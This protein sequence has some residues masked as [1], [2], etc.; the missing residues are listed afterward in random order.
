MEKKG[1]GGSQVTDSTQG[2]QHSPRFSCREENPISRKDRK[3]RW[4]ARLYTTLKKAKQTHTG[5]TL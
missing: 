5:Y 1:R 3:S 4:L 2:I